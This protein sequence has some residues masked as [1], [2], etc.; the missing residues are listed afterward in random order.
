MPYTEEQ[1]T[2][3]LETLEELLGI[4]GDDENIRFTNC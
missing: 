3:V 4:V 1:F 2:Q